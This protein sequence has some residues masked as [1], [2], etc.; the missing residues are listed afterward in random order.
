M[1]TDIL[2][3]Q[4]YEYDNPK[5]ILKLFVFYRRKNRHGDNQMTNVH[6]LHVE[7][8]RIYKKKEL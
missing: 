6:K 8:K 4:L 5:G 7:R 3:H 2:L 1:H